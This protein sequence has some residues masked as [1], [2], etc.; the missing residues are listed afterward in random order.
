MALPSHLYGEFSGYGPQSGGFSPLPGDRE[1]DKAR[2][3]SSKA[4][5]D[6]A[7]F[8]SAQVNSMSNMAARGLAGDPAQA[9]KVMTSGSTESKLI[10]DAAALVTSTGLVP[11]GNP[12]TLA[13]GVQ[14]MVAHSGMQVGG[15]VGRGSQ[16]FGYGKI[17]DMMSQSVFDKVKESFFNPATGLSNRAAHGL[18]Q[19]QMGE[20][21]SQL[22]AR[23]AF[24]GMNI[25]D[26]T[27][28]GGKLDFKIN[29]EQFSKV[30]N[31]VSDYAASLKSAKEI[32]GELDIADLTENAE[33]LIGASV[34]Q[35]GSTKA[36][37]DRLANITNAAAA[38]SADPAALAQEIMRTSDAVQYQM[39]SVANKDPRNAAIQSRAAMPQAF[40]KIAAGISEKGTIA[41]MGAQNTAQTAANAY[42]KQGV[43]MPTFSME[44]M[45]EYNMGVMQGIA[46]EENSTNLLPALNLLS[47]NLIKD[48][49]AKKR[50]ESLI[51]G[52]GEASSPEEQQRFN[53]AIAG[54]L[55]EQG[56]DAEIMRSQYTD[57]DLQGGLSSEYASMY[58]N[59]LGESGRNRSIEGVF[60][61]ME[62]S[63]KA[64]EVLSDE[65]RSTAIKELYKSFSKGTRD[66][67]LAAA[68]SPEKLQELYNKRPELQNVMSLEDLQSNL[69]A[70]G[71]D[72]GTLADM[73]TLADT[74]IRGASV[75]SKENKLAGTA[76]SVM[77]QL[78]AKSLGSGEPGS[79]V[80]NI[81][82]SFTDT[83]TVSDDIVMQSL[84][85]NRAEGS[86]L[87]EG[88]AKFERYGST[89]IN[90]PA[91]EIGK[92]KSTLGDDNF[93]NLV[94]ALGINPDDTEALSEALKG[95]AGMQELMKNL[96]GGIMK[97]QGYDAYLASEGLASQTIESLEKQAAA[98][99]TKELT[100]QAP[101]NLDTVEGRAETNEGIRSA[102]KGDN[103]TNLAAELEKSNFGGAKFEALKSAYGADPQ[104]KTM[105]DEQIKKTETE[106]GE[107]SQQ[108]VE[109]LKKLKGQL[110]TDSSNRGTAEYMGILHL[111]GDGI[112]NVGLYKK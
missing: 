21:I 93:N 78:D 94:N 49:D 31:I 86:P 45:K 40:S 53:D 16:V 61:A 83:G 96:G 105:L 107:G 47:K 57:A 37:K 33:R 100:G 24:A 112:A 72:V 81:I 50:L 74:E 95:P 13:A 84:L 4:L 77:Q 28:T 64:R 11:G 42:A 76:R 27:Q 34:S 6:Y 82:R 108:K 3:A 18:N 111:I 110:E 23:G 10:R 79:F 56:F 8:T 90:V 46:G 68:G 22:T 54:T 38:Y 32:F 5:S 97:M 14:K 98:S 85:N 89:G 75:E 91:S 20:A 9:A 87:P 102:L 19:T 69:A 62:F 99:A 48:P 80:E 65:G 58:T 101:K 71:T 92:L 60:T 26:I 15:D 43:Y 41:A 73:F 63:D 30:K 70:A 35:V 2:F 39:Y 25:G 29:K 12:A 67:I 66:E 55:K 1:F 17:T 104:L 109:S 88:M 106:G 103:L 44:A 36:M 51:K 59:T 7:L 52:F